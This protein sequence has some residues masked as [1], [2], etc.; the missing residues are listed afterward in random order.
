[1]RVFIFLLFLSFNVLAFE[2][3]PYC[4]RFGSDISQIILHQ[5]NQSKECDEMGSDEDW[6]EALAGSDNKLSY[7]EML[8]EHD[9]LA[10]KI[11]TLK[12]LYQSLQSFYQAIDKGEDIE[13]YSVFEQKDQIKL[14]AQQTL[15]LNSFHDF[16]K[17]KK[18]AGFFTGCDVGQGLEARIDCAC[19]NHPGQA[20]CSLRSSSGDPE[21]RDGINRLLGILEGSD[22][23]LIDDEVFW[24]QIS[25]A[26]QYLYPLGEAN[27]LMSIGRE[28]Q[29][30]YSQY[31]NLCIKRD[32]GAGTGPRTR[33]CRVEG[34]PFLLAYQRALNSYATRAKEIGNHEEMYR[35]MNRV[36]AAL[37]KKIPAI[38]QMELHA[39]KNTLREI[40]TQ[41]SGFSER[42]QNRNYSLKYHL[43]RYKDL[44]S[45]EDFDRQVY[46]DSEKVLS[47]LG[48]RI[49]S[50]SPFRCERRDETPNESNSLRQLTVSSLE[51]T[52]KNFK[53]CL[54]S[55]GDLNLQDSVGR[56]QQKLDKI[57]GKMAVYR[58]GNDFQK[59]ERAKLSF[60]KMMHDKCHNYFRRST[61]RSRFVRCPLP[62]R[63]GDSTNGVLEFI[64][65]NNRVIGDV[66]AHMTNLSNDRE[67]VCSALDEVEGL[68][69][70]ACPGHERHETVEERVRQRR[71]AYEER[72][73]NTDKEAV[74]TYRYYNPV[75][76]RL[77]YR[78]AYRRTRRDP[79]KY[80]KLGLLGGVGH[81]L[82]TSVQAYGQYQSFKQQLPYA[83]AQGRLKK[84]AGFCHNPVN[85]D[86]Q[87]F[88][89]FCLYGPGNLGR[90][91]LP[92][93]N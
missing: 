70:Y 12:L 46:S 48:I 83:V 16:L 81:V 44:E 50:R 54:E 53:Q 42:N 57:K 24:N 30:N 92:P 35:G 37:N 40:N 61:G 7:F 23:R 71:E 38:H 45:V 33:R 31:E 64:I 9:R 26:L 76:G 52:Q 72:E 67:E 1:M 91:P 88:E 15:L 73:E 89:S 20:I 3:D 68:N 39:R 17:A 87:T 66:Y 29:E 84:F 79:W 41:L 65:Q 27:L 49:S 25:S 55:L 82:S 47:Q 43:N 14:A 21:Q 28:I 59:L 60:V 77:E 75:T 13:E 5:Q 58:Q 56:L 6:C 74:G 19:N 34:R 80:F 90:Y 22:S 63:G 69:L 85:L 10:A 62:D 78:T 11:N 36:L 8:K 93:T 4:P 32:R 18:D 2:D 86:M 51:D